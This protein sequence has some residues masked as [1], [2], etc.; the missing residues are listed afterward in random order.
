MSLPVVLVDAL[1]DVED[2]LQRRYAHDY[3]I[4]STTDPE[5]AVRELAELAPPKACARS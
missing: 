3:R 2:Q 1:R 5:Q 4:E